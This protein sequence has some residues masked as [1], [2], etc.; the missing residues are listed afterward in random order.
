MNPPSQF[1]RGGKIG[2]P[3]EHESGSSGGQQNSEGLWAY[4]KKRTKPL[5]PLFKQKEEWIS[6]KSL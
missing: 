2:K 3:G 4:Q 5:P 6:K 1:S